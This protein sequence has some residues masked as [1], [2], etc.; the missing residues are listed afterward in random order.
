MSTVP[1]HR[2]VP[3]C[4]PEWSGQIRSQFLLLHEMCQ[5]RRIRQ[6]SF[7]R[8]PD[9]NCRPS[10]CALGRDCNQ[11]SD[12]SPLNLGHCRRSH[13]HDKVDGKMRVSTK[14]ISST[15]QNHHTG[16]VSIGRDSEAAW[17]RESVSCRY[18]KLFGTHSVTGY[19]DDGTEVTRT[20]A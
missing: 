17:N 11:S 19:Q 5:C 16:S 12:L 13:M 14:Y 8:R 15:T 6:M 2:H 10:R 18:Q 4:K 3:P 9:L 7:A 20:M 1:E